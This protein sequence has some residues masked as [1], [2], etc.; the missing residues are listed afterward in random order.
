VSHEQV[1]GPK[2]YVGKSKAT[3]G[4]Y[5]QDQECLDIHLLK[6]AGYE[7]V[8]NPSLGLVPYT[9]DARPEWVTYLYLT[10]HSMLRWLPS[11]LA[12]WLAENLAEVLAIPAK[13]GDKWGVEELN[14]GTVLERRL[15][16]SVSTGAHLRTQCTDE[17]PRLAAI[18][19]N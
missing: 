12:E 15:F 17:G 10:S 18:M 9:D 8:A 1:L 14:T 5:H 11:K 2:T 4:N 16:S 19:F 13:L 3:C 6:A 7:A